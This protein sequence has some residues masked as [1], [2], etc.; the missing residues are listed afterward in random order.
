MKLDNYRLN[1]DLILKKE[2]E[3]LSK[4]YPDI[5]IKGSYT[6]II[7][8]LNE[9]KIRS[10]II[11]HKN[12]FIGYAYIMDSQDKSD[13]LYADAGFVSPKKITD[14]RVNELF[15]WLIGIAKESRKKLM[16]NQIF[17]GN[18]I[19]DKYLVK[20][21]FKTIV[22]KRMAIDLN[23]YSYKKMDNINEVSG[24]EDLNLDLYA[25]AE[26]EAF[27]YTSDKYLFSN[28]RED[29][30]KTVKNLF[31]GDYGEIINECSFVLKNKGKISGAVVSSK[32]GFDRAF[33]VSIFVKRVYRKK[34]MGKFLLFTALN[35][36]KA[37]SYHYV[38]LWVNSENFAQD[39]YSH[40]G[41]KY[42]NYPD[43][44]IYYLPD[45]R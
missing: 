17:N 39:F 28:K 37:L 45:A 18:E 35:R 9:N 25:D 4:K 19:S 16:L 27:K 2:I 41:F 3:F 26:Y 15:T 38:F 5:D 30:I 31:N 43:E 36:L 42:D 12:Q 7:N 13:R 21:G 40:Y 11:M 14:E 10:R 29:R 32:L 24:I 1:W 33:I 8:L 23:D 34:G 44:I 20:C 22:R 6:S